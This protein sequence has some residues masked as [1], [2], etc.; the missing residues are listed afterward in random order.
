MGKYVQKSPNYEKKRLLLV[1]VV[2]LLAVV[3]TLAAFQVPRFMEGVYPQVDIRSDDS[4]LSIREVVNSIEE[5]HRSEGWAAYHIF[6]YYIQVNISE[7]IWAGDNLAH[8]IN[9]TFPDSPLSVGH[10]VEVGDD[11]PNKPQITVGQMIE[12]KGFYL[13]VTESPQSSRLTIAPAIS[14]SYL[15]PQIS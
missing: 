15:K 10:I 6:R 9:G 13:A 12:C 14:G 11:Y 2:V 8:W 4:N 3:I 1:S 7:T 5:N